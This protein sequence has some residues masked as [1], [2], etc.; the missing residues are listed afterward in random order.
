MYESCEPGQP[1]LPVAAASG[2]IRG[3]GETDISGRRPGLSRGRQRKA[4]IINDFSSF[5]RCSLMVSVPI[6]SAM[7]IQCCPVPTSIFTNH[8]GFSR[9]SKLDCTEWISH[10]IA[11]WKSID[12]AFEAIQTGFLASQ[13]QMDFVLEFVKSF[14][15]E[16]TL[17]AVDPVMGDYGR[18]YTSYDPALA[19]RMHELLD[20]ADILTPNLTEA[21]ILAGRP[22]PSNP[23]DS[24]IAD[25]AA[26]LCSRHAKCAVI[27]G[28]HRGNSLLNFIHSRDSGCEVVEVPKIGTDRSGTGDVF[29]SVILGSMMRGRS[30]GNSVRAAATFVTA[31]VKKAEELEIPVT[32]GLP[33]EETLS[34]LWS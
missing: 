5:G 22:F 4:A 24:E 8:T 2:I 30:F 3:M 9:F 34:S 16:R 26:E 27:S 21:C 13:A 12:L 1:R 29:A 6:L 20:V 31:T 28:V 15:T 17:M 19:A 25:L 23:D 11:D 32:D 7:R 10:Y 18:L 14:R 33:V